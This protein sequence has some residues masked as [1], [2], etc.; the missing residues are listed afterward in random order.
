MHY[1]GDPLAMCQFNVIRDW[2]ELQ[3]EAHY[4]NTRDLRAAPAG[5]E[6]LDD[7]MSVTGSSEQ[8]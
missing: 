6:L 3:P 7:I 1:A 2:A 8:E 4:R 5:M